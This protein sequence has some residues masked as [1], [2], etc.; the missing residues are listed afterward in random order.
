MEDAIK[1]TIIVEM[2]GRPKEHLESTL[3]KLVEVLGKEKGVK[4]IK[5]SVQEPKVFQTENER[6]ES[7]KPENQLYTSFTEIE[8]EVDNINNLIRI[9]FK[10]MPAHVEVLSPTKINLN[11]FEIS[12]LLSDITTR[13]HHYDAIAKNAL[14]NNQI[15]ANRLKE[16]EGK[17]DSK[18]IA[19][20]QEKTSTKKSKKK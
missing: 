14:M 13:L 3:K 2:L 1:T 19:E 15:L 10:Y 5:S 17:T 18:E 12:G 20:A 8:M 6:G 4:I 16:L 7:I 11:N 9:V